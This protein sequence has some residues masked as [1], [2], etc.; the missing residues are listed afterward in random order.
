MAGS[1]RE[2]EESLGRERKQG[3]LMGGHVLMGGTGC[4][5]WGL[6]GDKWLQ[7][8]LRGLVLLL[9]Y[10][11]LVSCLLTG[12]IFFSSFRCH[13]FHNVKNSY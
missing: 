8:K 11:I 13:V 3:V 9:S 5:G 6:E 12:M 2:A 10:L 1:E 4:L 7:S